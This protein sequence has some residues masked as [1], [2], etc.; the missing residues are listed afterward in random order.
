MSDKS[1]FLSKNAQAAIRLIAVILVNLGIVFSAVYILFHLLDYYNPHGFVSH[2]MPWLPIVIPI[3]FVL[4]VLL[5]D[6]L[7]ISGSFKKHYF[8]KKRMWLIILC[9][10]ILFSALS[11]TMYLRT[12]TTALVDHNAI[13]EYQLPTPT[14]ARTP[15]PLPTQDP[16]SGADIPIVTPDSETEPSATAEVASEVPAP[17]VPLESKFPD[18]YSETPAEQAFDRSNIVETLS[19]GTQKA[20]IYTYSGRNAAV[21]IYH[22]KKGKLEYQL[23]DIYVRDIDCFTTNFSISYKR[24]MKTQVY[25]E[26]IHAIV[27][28]NGDNFNSGKIEDGI[29]IRNGAQ[30]YPRDGARQTKYSRDL[31]VLYS[32]GTM[33]VYDCVTDRIDYDEII[34]RYPRQAFYFGPKLLNDDGTAKTKF[35]SNLGKVNPRTLLGYY[36]P[37]HYAL[38]VVLGTREMIDYR[39]KNRGNG[40]SPGMTLIEL[41]ALCEQLEFTMAYNLDGGGSS[42]MVWNKTVFGHND[43]THSDILAVVDP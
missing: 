34:G 36:E 7:L 22:F 33:K 19:D 23:A 4:S 18:K 25:A 9:D 3:L 11:L 10:I 27:S 12:C 29:V 30:L 5:Y 38:V 14:A 28:A 41:S 6:L 37:G 21:D 17:V 20:L 15:V 40:K 35:N 39:G 42:S 26:Q 16:E 1:S 31:C 13:E 2:N 24:N 32:D 43:R 8:N